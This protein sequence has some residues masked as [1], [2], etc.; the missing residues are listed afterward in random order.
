VVRDCA[1]EAV[2]G[3]GLRALPRECLSLALAGLRTRPREAVLEIRSAPWRE[4]LS[5]LTLPLAATIL[6]VWIFGF[7]PRY[8]HWPLGEGWAMLLG[9]SLLAVVGAALRHRWLTAAG[10]AA[11][12]VAAASPYLG[13]GTDVAI[14]HTPSFY[15]G[16][17]VDIGAASLLPTLLL[18]AGALTLP[19]RPRPP[20]REVMG[21]LALGLVPALVAIG[22]LLP[23]PEPEPTRT[24]VYDA[25][26][27]EVGRTVEVVGP[28]VVVGPPYPMPW[29]FPSRTLVA[30]V[31][32]AL[33]LAIVVT[34]R[35][36]RT[37]PAH[38]LATGLVLA[39]LAYPLVW[40]AIRTE[41]VPTPYWMYNGA[42]PLLLA[43]LPLLLALVL[44]RRAGRATVVPRRTAP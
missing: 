7:V 17:S 8:D 28:T 19:P 23:A 6:V 37:H 5:V 3:A 31:G 43:V 9:G 44:M 40:V 42:Y 26:K 14:A 41:P 29:I 18:V 13:Y 12:L 36:N 33:A 30:A 2:D 15:T 39:S 24:F 4:A 38:A 10:A 32:I 35:R 22:Y 16:W 27:P 20:V 1:R 21:R 34:W 11:T 25:I